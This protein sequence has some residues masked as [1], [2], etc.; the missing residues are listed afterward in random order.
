M[1]VCTC[2]AWYAWIIYKVSAH[3]LEVSF[4]IDGLLKKSVSAETKDKKERGEGGEDC[5]KLAPVV[6]KEGRVR[7]EMSGD[8]C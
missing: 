8:E 5:W 6:K 7:V 4:I 2:S 3:L 1:R